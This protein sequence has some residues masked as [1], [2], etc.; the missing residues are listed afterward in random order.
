ML[1]QVVL[2]LVSCI[3]LIHSQCSNG[4]LTQVGID[5]CPGGS[6]DVTSNDNGVSYNEAYCD[7]LGTS[8]CTFVAC[9]SPTCWIK[10]VP[11]GWSWYS[12][13]SVT[14]YTRCN[15]DPTVIPTAI[16]TLDPSSIP[17]TI[18]S[19]IPTYLPSYVPTTTPR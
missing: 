12:N 14:S 5:I 2:L 6:C 3:Y 8:E 9:V 18:P 7:Q 19:R 10:K 4:W 15:R 13:P 17:T 1:L 16:P 11:S